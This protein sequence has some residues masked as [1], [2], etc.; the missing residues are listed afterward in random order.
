MDPDPDSDPAIH[1]PSINFFKKFFC[2]L[3]FE[4]TFTSFFK[5]EKSKRSHKWK[6]SRNQGFS[7][8]FCLMIEGSGS[9][10]IPLTNGSGSRR[11]KNIRIRIRIRNT[12]TNTYGSGSRRP[13]PYE[14]YWSGTL[15]TDVYDP[16]N[17]TCPWLIWP[18]SIQLVRGSWPH[19][20]QQS[21]YINLS[22]SETTKKIKKRKNQQPFIYLSIGSN[23]AKGKRQYHYARI[24]QCNGSSPHRLG[25]N[26]FTFYDIFT[27]FS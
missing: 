16:K 4:G 1:W 19:S 25:V 27:I 26:N 23:F 15:I 11:P 10:S 22:I 7:Y 12:G 9:G 21:I 2:W 5:D 18:T 8:Y 24:K 13:K 6:N 17:C 20:R 14:S 3:L